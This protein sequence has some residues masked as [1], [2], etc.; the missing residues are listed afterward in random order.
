MTRAIIIG[1]PNDPHV[2][3][4]REQLRFKALIFDASSLRD[5]RYSLDD[6]GLTVVDDGERRVIGRE[7]PLRGWARRIAPDTWLR[8]VRADSLEAAE[9]SAWMSLLA[10]ILQFEGVAWL[11]SIGAITRAEN[12]LT[13]AEAARRVGVR[14]PHT[15]V[16][17]DVT[18]VG[19]ALGREVVVKPLGV[20]H[21]MDAGKPHTVHA[22]SAVAA[23]L[24]TED[25]AVAPFLIQ[26]KLRAVRHWRVVTVGAEAWS[27]ALDAKGYSL[28]WRR[29]SL[30]HSSFVDVV[31]PSPV[32]KGALA[33]AA[34][35]NL[36][37][38]SQDW[39]E[40]DEGVYLVDVNP[41]GQWLFLPESIGSEVAA[42]IARWLEGSMFAGV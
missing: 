9:A 40:T 35:L 32:E 21:Y 28:D 5:R 39:I 19:S 29:D 15:I 30:A 16:T 6:R 20:G 11:T 23:E 27:A 14:T 25:L 1:E 38:S 17:N 12:K 42:A 7:D 18:F 22:T 26:Q 2:V 13:Q 36:G 10:A 37:Y 3:A 34:A 33:T 4:V 24:R 31:A 8:S 41:S